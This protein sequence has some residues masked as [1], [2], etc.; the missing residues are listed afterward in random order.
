M[1]LKTAFEPYF[2]VGVAMSRWNI[3]IK[4]HVEL[5]KAQYS[6]FTAENDM[7]PMYFIDTEEGSGEV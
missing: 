2:K 6:S 1:N 3:H 5:M 4:A 7:K